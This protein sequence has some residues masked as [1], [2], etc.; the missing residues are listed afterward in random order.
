MAKIITAEQAAELVKSGD[1]LMV[2]GFML[3]GTPLTLVDAI[4]DRGLD[5]FT[6]IAND[7]GLPGKGAGRLICEKRVKHM[8][9]SH[10][11]TNKE[12]G[13]LMSTGEMKIDLVPQGTLAERIRTGGAGLGGFLTPTGI[14]T[15]AEEGKQKIAK[16]GMEYLIEDPLRA[17]VAL[18]R[19]HKADKAGNLVYRGATRNFNVPMATAADIVIVE[20]EEIVEIGGMDPDM[21]VTPGIFVDYLVQR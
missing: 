3:A 19:A 9:A 8:I 7:A 4:C 16:N 1:S 5:G 17:K 13:A 6:L 21:V 12:A 2:G 15:Q 11:G 14:G 10:I 18:I 20:V